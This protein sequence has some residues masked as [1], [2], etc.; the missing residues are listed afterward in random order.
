MKDPDEG[1]LCRSCGRT[2]TPTVSDAKKT[3][4]E[5]LRQLVPQPMDDVTF[6]ST[7]VSVLELAELLQVSRS[8]LS[9]RLLT[10]RHTRLFS[11]WGPDETS[12]S[13][14]RNRQIRDRVVQLLTHIAY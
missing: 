5:E 7:Y 6:A 4:M 13:Q 10:R 14:N 12:V 3:V 2:F 1:L 8:S 9:R 11:A